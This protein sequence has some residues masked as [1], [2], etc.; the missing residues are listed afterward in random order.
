MLGWTACHSWVYFMWVP[1]KRLYMNAQWRTWLTHIYW[2]EEKWFYTFVPVQPLYRLHHFCTC[3]CT[4]L[5]YVNISITCDSPG[6]TSSLYLIV[7]SIP[8][9]QMLTGQFLELLNYTCVHSSI[10]YVWPCIKYTLMEEVQ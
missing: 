8:K 5:Y 9:R 6:C 2:G 4:H 7:V 3:I 1:L 10:K